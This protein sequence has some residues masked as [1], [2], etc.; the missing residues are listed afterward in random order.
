MGMRPKSDT[1]DV[2][3]PPRGPS[4]SP[5]NEPCFTQLDLNHSDSHRVRDHV[6]PLEKLLQFPLG[7]NRKS[8]VFITPRIPKPD[9]HPPSSVTSLTAHL[10]AGPGWMKLVV[11][12]VS[13]LANFVLW[14]QLKCPSHQSTIKFPISSKFKSKSTHEDPGQ[15]QISQ[16]SQFLLASLLALKWCWSKSN[17]I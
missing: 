14:F 1:S 11:S 15:I 6:S 17:I 5:G 4:A 9:A 16:S 2:Q 7:N 12:F 3:L 13:T 10:C 8:T